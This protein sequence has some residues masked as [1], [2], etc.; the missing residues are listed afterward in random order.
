MKDSTRMNIASFVIC[1]AMAC[2][3]SAEDECSKAR[4]AA[5]RGL[6]P[7]PNVICSCV[8]RAI[9]LSDAAQRKRMPAMS[10]VSSDVGVTDGRLADGDWAYRFHVTKSWT[11]E[12]PRWP[13]VDLPTAVRDWTGYDRL[14]LDV[15]NDSDGGDV[16]C[17]YLSECGKRLQDGLCPRRGLPL[18]DCSFRRWTISLKNWPKTV[19]PSNI[20]RIHLFF[21]AP[22]CADV[23]VSGFYLLKPG[24][25]PPALSREFVESKMKPAAAKAEVG[26][27]ERRRRHVEQFV[28]RCRSAGQKGDVAWI[29]K[30]TSM[31]KV[32]PRDEF[33][34][35]AADSFELRL[36]HGEFESLQVL[37]MPV[38]EDLKDVTV[39]TVGMSMDGRE[40]PAS[41]FKVSPVGY[42][43]TVNPPPYR[44]AEN[45]V[46]NLPGGYFR[47]TKRASVG[48]WPDPILDWLDRADVRKGDLQS[49]WVRLKCPMDQTPGTYRGR[50]RVKG[51]RGGSEWSEDFP[52]SVRVYS[53]S[54]PRKSPLPL[55]LTFSPEPSLQ[56]ADEEQL[57]LARRL[58]NDPESPVNAWKRHEAEW[59]EF[60]ADYY[61]TMDSLYHKGKSIRWDVLLR[62]KRE[63]RLGLFNLGYWSYPRDMSDA[64]LEEWMK[65][66]RLKYDPVVDKARS[67]GL[68]QNA[69]IYGCDEASTN[70]F[71]NIRWSL[72]R[73][74]EMYPDIRLF[75]T[76][77]DKSF[78]AD[79]ALAKMDWFCPTTVVYSKNPA[80]IAAARERGHKVWWYI[81]C[82][83]HSPYANL[84]VEY[85]AIEARQLM[86]A[87]A[88]RWRPD[89]FLYY[90]LSI[91]NSLR[92]IAGKDT[93][94]DWEPRSWTQYHG[95]G[96]W[97]C[98]GPDGV[99]CATIRMENFRDGL[100]D[101]AYAQEYERVTGRKCD[102]P[103]SVCRE[104][105]QFS[106]SPEAYSSWR[107]AMAE[108]IEAASETR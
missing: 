47:K 31:E 51:L 83:P 33:D 99:P 8:R 9:D 87:Q 15:F 106:D 56:F 77:Y 93:F 5:T 104:I 37:V 88:V 69:Y 60:L 21:T 16:L 63:G 89:G 94:T 73:L 100:E 24:E 92:P 35:K 95:D 30:A 1:A 3:A 29:G 43:C 25:Q 34:V 105:D 4:T 10:R 7:K 81:A 17:C 50:L 46:T 36:A 67:L 86:G 44:I 79:A 45:V 97:F 98:C 28:S 59:G 54:V 57:E 42:I 13:S 74:K 71:A 61:V 101:F 68:L 27:A 32:R 2:V 85:Q 108:A 53:F 11:G 41:A 12:L 58:K 102:V 48:W 19:N 84:F 72:E 80:G 20:G 49:F 70:F 55:A 26:R 107:N 62:L 22:S 96:S 64:V 40:I 90:Q 39:E 18:G 66:I 65:N 78:G 82:N 52:F 6:D 23:H 91:W 75:T 103:V 76:A 14:V 38:S